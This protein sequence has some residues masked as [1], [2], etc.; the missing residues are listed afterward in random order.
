MRI[1][2]V[3]HASVVIDCGDVVL[4]TDP[5]LVGNAFNDAWTP[6]P[7]PVLPD[8]LLARVTHVWVSHEHPDHLSIGTL[9]A[10]PAERRAGI[11]FLYQTPWSEEVPSFLRRLGW[12]SVLELPHGTYVPLGAGVQACVFQVGHEDSALVVRADGTTVLDLNDCKP[13]RRGLA[14]L[15]EVTGRIDVL[16]DQF[17]IAGWPG[18]PEETSRHKER[19]ARAL[20]TFG[21]HVEAL[22]PRWVVPFASFVRFSHEENAFMNAAVV[23]AGAAAERAGR[24]RAAVLYPGDVWDPTGPP[25]TAAAL[26]RYAQA[27]AE[28]PAQP[29]HGSE[30]V[31]FDEVVAAARVRVADLRAAYHAPLLRTVRPVVFSVT[32]AGRAFVVDLA[33]GRV[34]PCP[35]EGTTVVEVSSQAAKA[36]FT[37]RWGLPT[38]LISGRLRVRGDERPFRRLKQLGSAWSTG[39]HTKG[40]LR[41]AVTTDRGRQAVRRLVPRPRGL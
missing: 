19:S 24:E 14:R 17:S 33:R 35:P 10:I 3:G 1:H 11:T 38:L 29:V 26:E 5:W 28:S 13:G 41:R 25:P 32:D 27:Y 12:A 20:V 23:P 18:N 37:D 4:L 15:R 36:A 9:K 22:Q 30:P 34:E 6:W 31:P 2:F 39:V 21:R 7:P 40:A 8:D 16:L